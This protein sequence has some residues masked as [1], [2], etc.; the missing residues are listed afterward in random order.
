M[1]LRLRKVNVLVLI[2]H[3]VIW[4][5]VIE[6]VALCCNLWGWFFLVLKRNWVLS[7]HLGSQ[8]RGYWRNWRRG[9]KVIHSWSDVS[10]R[11]SFVRGW[12]LLGFCRRIKLVNWTKWRLEGWWNSI[13][14]SNRWLNCRVDRIFICWI[15]GGNWR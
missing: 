2:V 9:L 14:C 1:I 5:I 7:R 10:I 13:R 15:A 6:G 11:T 4:G 3:I 8:W 12:S